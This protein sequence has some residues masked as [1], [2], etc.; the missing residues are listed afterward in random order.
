MDVPPPLPHGQT[1]RLGHKLR[2]CAIFLG[3]VVVIGTCIYR[4]SPFRTTT[5]LTAEQANRSWRIR[6]PVPNTA[7]NVCMF[8]QGGPKSFDYVL[9]FEA[10]L[11]N[12]EE[13]A[14]QIIDRYP[15]SWKKTAIKH[16]ALYPE[17]PH[18]YFSNANLQWFDVHLMTNGTRWHYDQERMKGSPSIYQTIWIDHDHGVLYLTI[19]D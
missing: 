12:C 9:R 5:P 3:C 1:T 17:S 13:F 19:G 14:K 11:A 8:T 16:N 6:D 2:V 10:P 18:V 7:S 4:I 15:S